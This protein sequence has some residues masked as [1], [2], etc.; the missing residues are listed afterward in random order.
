MPI[1]KDVSFT[2]SPG[3]KLAIVGPTGSG[4]STLIRLLGRFYDFDDNQIFLDGIDLN[5]IHS[6][7][8]RRRVGVVP[9]GLS[10]FSQAASTTT[11]P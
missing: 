7:D 10:I 6:G 4:K 3:E 5:Q 9:A 1:L 11:L 8:L 2:I